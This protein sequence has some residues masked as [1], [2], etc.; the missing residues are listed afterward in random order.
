MGLTK[1][2]RK[3]DSN[4]RWTVDDFKEWNKDIRENGWQRHGSTLLNLLLTVMQL[5]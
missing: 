2:N 4:E 3:L 1:W 5:K